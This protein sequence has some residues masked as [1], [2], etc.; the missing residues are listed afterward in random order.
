MSNLHG[1][2]VPG[3]LISR[4]VLMGT[5]YAR[6]LVFI[7][8]VDEKHEMTSMIYGGKFFTADEDVFSINNAAHVRYKG[9]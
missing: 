5:H 7:V 1:G 9:V 6:V 2:V 8:S 3:Q 4:V